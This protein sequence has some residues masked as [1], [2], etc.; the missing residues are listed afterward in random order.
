MHTLST[1]ESGGLHHLG[2]GSIISLMMFHD[3]V[4]TWVSNH[5]QIVLIE[6]ALDEDRWAKTFQTRSPVPLN[7]EDILKNILVQRPSS[8]AHDAVQ[9]Q[10]NNIIGG[11]NPKCQLQLVTFAS[12]S[13]NL[14]NL[15]CDK[16]MIAKVV[17]CLLL[18][19]WV[20][21]P[22]SGRASKVSLT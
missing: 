9:D 21:I 13:S 3:V 5:K 8:P 22:E 2:A 6:P 14:N 7:T 16:M 15:Y 10:W 12:L 11:S 18:R 1:G 20:R 17:G 4:I 19:T